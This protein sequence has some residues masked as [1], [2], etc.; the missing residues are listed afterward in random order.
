MKCNDCLTE[1]RFSSKNELFF[2]TPE[3]KTPCEACKEKFDKIKE[4]SNRF[5]VTLTIQ[6]INELNH[7]LDKMTKV[8]NVMISMLPKKKK[9]ALVQRV[10]Q[11]L[12][13]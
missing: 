4:W 6:T 8:T 10:K 2:Y 12:S 1:V 9:S 11:W 7:N 5:P 3:G 13:L